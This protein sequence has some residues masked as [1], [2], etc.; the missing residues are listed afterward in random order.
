MLKTY[1]S[2]Y[3]SYH[4]YRAKTIQL[5]VLNRKSHSRFRV[6][7]RANRAKSERFDKKKKYH[8]RRRRCVFSRKYG[9]SLELQHAGREKKVESSP[10]VSVLLLFEAQ[11][12]GREKNVESSPDGT[13]VL[14]VRRQSGEDRTRRKIK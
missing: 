8:F 10:E 4:T 9:F 2:R 13:G 6:L 12:A 11:H 3:V 14:C 1:D 7:N 5:V